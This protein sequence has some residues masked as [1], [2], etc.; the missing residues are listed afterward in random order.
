MVNGQK[1]MKSKTLTETRV[2]TAELIQ[3]K[4]WRYRDFDQYGR[5]TNGHSFYCISGGTTD[6]KVHEARPWC[7]V[8]FKTTVRDLGEITIT[9]QR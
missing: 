9:D 8:P 2:V 4:C 5:P 7:G 1:L 3:A 6:K